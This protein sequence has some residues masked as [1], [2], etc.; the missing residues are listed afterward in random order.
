MAREL[1]ALLLW[2]R[3]LRVSALAAIPGG[4]G[5]RAGGWECRSTPRPGGRSALHGEHG[6]AIL[7]AVWGT[8][9]FICLMRA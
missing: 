7:C 5:S 4:K 2:G 8:G 9:R 1:R 6:D 3:R